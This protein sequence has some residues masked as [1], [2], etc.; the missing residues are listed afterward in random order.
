M[1]CSNNKYDQRERKY[2]C[3]KSMPQC[4]KVWDCPENWLNKTFMGTV[5]KGLMIME[6]SR[7]IPDTKEKQNFIIN[8]LV[9]G[10]KE[11]LKRCL[12]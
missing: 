5:H 7:G 6:N 4:K 9:E 3:S 10:I 8:K 2:F 11:G 1:N 12:S